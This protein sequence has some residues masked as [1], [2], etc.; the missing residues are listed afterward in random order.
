[1][2][3]PT[4]TEGLQRYHHHQS[5]HLILEWEQYHTHRYAASLSESQ[6]GASTGLNISLARKNAE[7]KVFM[8]QHQAEPRSRVAV[9]QLSPEPLSG[10]GLPPELP[11][12]GA[13]AAAPLWRPSP[14]PSWPLAL[15]VVVAS[16]T[17]ALMAPPALSDRS[18][19][20]HPRPRGH[21]ALVIVLASP[22]PSWPRPLVIIL[23]LVALAIVVVSSSAPGGTPSSGSTRS[24]SCSSP[25]V[26]PLLHSERRVNTGSRSAA[27]L[28]I[29]LRSRD[30]EW[31][32]TSPA[33]VPGDSWS[34]CV[35]ATADASKSA[36]RSCHQR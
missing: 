12:E 2:H 10:H 35:G 1:M 29:L 23:A 7:S 19:V 28:S 6:F 16:L 24:H 36:M 3:A 13:T 32:C 31:C 20:P 25:V 14:S 22:S 11:P 26:V 33:Q 9:D 8:G 5:H 4:I 30:A 15:V 27:C 34:F 17:L 21:P 18:C